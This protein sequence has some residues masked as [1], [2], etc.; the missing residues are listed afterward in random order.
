[1][2]KA[3]I[4]T[5]TMVEP[6]GVPARMDVRIPSTAQKTERIAEQRITDLKF[7]N[8]RIAESAGKMTKAEI[9]SEPT[10]FMASTIIMAVMTAI[11]RLYWSAFVPVAFA[12]SS[13][14]VTANILW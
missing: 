5:A 2:A 9:S 14:K 1:M 10:R 12:K 8:K 13:S 6:T 11:S 3:A 7:L 4:S